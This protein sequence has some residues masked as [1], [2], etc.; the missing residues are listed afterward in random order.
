MI[1]FLFGEEDIICLFGS[2]FKI[3]IVVVGD[4]LLN[5]NYQELKIEI[6]VF[7]QEGVGLICCYQ[8][9]W[10]SVGKVVVVVDMEVLDEKKLALLACVEK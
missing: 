6:N 10:D 9:K 4:F 5:M 7:K 2:C 3:W 8:F 1:L